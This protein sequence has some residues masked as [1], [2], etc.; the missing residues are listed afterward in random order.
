MSRLKILLLFGEFTNHIVNIEKA[1]LDEKRLVEVLLNAESTVHKIEPDLFQKP[2]DAQELK[3]TI[4]E[5]L[6]TIKDGS[7]NPKIVA[8]EFVGILSL[9][10]KLY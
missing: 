9:L 1:N 7:G 4:L 5:L 8:S 10:N 6:D 2:E 3:E